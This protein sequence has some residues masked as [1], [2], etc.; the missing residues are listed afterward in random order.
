MRSEQPRRRAGPRP[1]A[2]VRVLAA[3]TAAAGLVVVFAPLPQE[4]GAAARATAEALPSPPAP[5]GQDRGGL[6]YQQNCATCHGQDGRGT[7]RGPSLRG[8]GEASVD[9]QLGTGRMP[10]P[11]EHVDPS[12]SEPAFSLEDI[13]A[14]VRHVSEFAGAGPDIPTVVPSDARLGQELYLNNCA[15]CHSATG[16]G[17]TL[18]E[19]EFAPSLFQATP[20]QV[21]EAIRVGPGLMPTFP[22]EVIDAEQV[23]ALA[24]YIDVL[25][26]EHGD[27]DRGGLPLGRIG[28]VTEAIIGWT[29]GLL[30]LVIVIRWLGS[31]A[32]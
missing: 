20:T 2:V 21:G 6:L 23:N 5:A 32:R 29:V 14:L 31:R 12:R 18:T 9:F 28:P 4:H 25:Q 24:A 17:G 15:A 3:L 27:L 16:T 7:Q 13:N 30:L 11:N 8:V 10:L 19:E 22:E 26:D 1:A